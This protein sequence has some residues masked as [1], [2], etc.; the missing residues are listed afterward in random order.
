[1]VYHHMRVMPLAVPISI[2]AV[3]LAMVVILA[4]QVKADPAL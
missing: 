1:M 3:I 4:M 2:I